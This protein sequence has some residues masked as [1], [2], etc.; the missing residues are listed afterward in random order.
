MSLKRSKKCYFYSMQLSA[1]DKN[2]LQHYFS[3]IPVKRAYV[4]GSYARHTAIK[5]FS[6]LDIMVEL[7]HTNPIGMNFFTYQSDL[8]TLLKRKVDLVSSEGISRHIKPKI[9]QEKILIYERIGG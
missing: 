7:D 8:Q 3:E 6:D 9:D 2:I 1:S 4:F 5:E